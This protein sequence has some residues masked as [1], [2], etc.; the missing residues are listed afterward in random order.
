MKK[1]LAV[2]FMGAI[3]TSSSFADHYD[4]HYYHGGHFGGPGIALASIFG[5]AVIA[6]A[7]IASQQPTYVYQPAPVYYYSAPAPV[8]YQSAPTVVQQTAAPAPAPATTVT[9][10]GTAPYG[11]LS[12]GQLRS[13]YSDF[14]LSIGGL[15][16]GNVLYDPHTGQPFMVP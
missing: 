8:Y 10:Q 15:T 9:T 4:H 11:I 5:A 14:T 12:E 1:F 6:D 2:L 13:P 3:L 7:V 16:R